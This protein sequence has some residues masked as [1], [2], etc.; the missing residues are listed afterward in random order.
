MTIQSILYVPEKRAQMELSPM[1]GLDHP[2]LLGYDPDKKNEVQV[3][4]YARYLIMQT[5]T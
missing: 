1:V 3:H 2:C 5:K 4:Q